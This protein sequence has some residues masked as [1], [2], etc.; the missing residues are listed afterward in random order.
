MDQMTFGPCL[1]HLGSAKKSAYSVNQGSVLE[2][3]NS[4]TM[5]SHPDLDSE[6]LLLNVSQSEEILIIS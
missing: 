6:W 4:L 3:K 2:G 5:L 1:V